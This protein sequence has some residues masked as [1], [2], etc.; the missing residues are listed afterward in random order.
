MTRTASQTHP[1]A[2]PDHAQKPHWPSITLEVLGS[3]LALAAIPVFFFNW[4]DV[5]L[6]FFGETPTV[7]AWN[8]TV[9]RI[10]LALLAGGTLLALG[11]LYWRRFPL[12]R[13]AYWHGFVLVLGIAAAL[14]FHV[15]V[16][17]S[18]TEP[19]PAQQAHPACF[20]GGDSDECPGG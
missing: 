8:V 5:Y 11:A 20:S 13:S 9:Y 10:A 2:A 14:V 7:E 19:P 1:P 18:S 4:L 12:G 15:G 16:E 17:H 6:V 3:L